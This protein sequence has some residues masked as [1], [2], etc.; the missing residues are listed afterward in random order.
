M[1]KVHVFLVSLEFV[2]KLC[3]SLYARKLKISW[4]NLNL[5]KDFDLS[6]LK[7]DNQEP[8]EKSCS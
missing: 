6:T 8:E 3:C 1:W 4:K 7:N 2:S 5:V